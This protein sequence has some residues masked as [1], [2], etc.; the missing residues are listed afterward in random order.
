MASDGLSN[1]QIGDRLFRSPHGQLAPVPVLSQARG[2][3]PP[4]GTRRD[5]PR[6]HANHSTRKHRKRDPS[7]GLLLVSPRP[8][9]RARP[10][11]RN[12]HVR[13]PGTWYLGY[14]GD[15]LA[16][17]VRATEGPDPAKAT[18]TAWKYRNLP[19]FRRNWQVPAGTVTCGNRRR[20]PA[21]EGM[22]LAGLPSIAQ[23]RRRPEDL[24]DRRTAGLRS[25]HARP[26]GRDDSDLPGELLP[27][28]AIWARAALTGSA[29]VFACTPRPHPPSGV[30]VSSTQVRPAGGGVAGGR[31]MISARWRTT[32]SCLTRCSAKLRG[33]FPAVKT[34]GTATPAA[35]QAS[36]KCSSA[37]DT[38]AAAS[39]RTIVTR[40]RTSRRGPAR[41]SGARRSELQRH[42]VPRRTTANPPW[43]RLTPFS[44]GVRPSQ[45]GKHHDRT[46]FPRSL[47]RIAEGGGQLAGGRPEHGR[48][49]GHHAGSGTRRRGGQS[50][51]PGPGR[52]EP[53]RCHSA[54]S[55]RLLRRPRRP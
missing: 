13:D 50:L 38:P 23:S 24:P 37:A 53:R 27:S 18:G 14:D 21:A 35:Q 20:R 31:W 44:A 26:G 17:G 3:R 54:S 1:R 8:G 39:R 36:A 10:R 12:A 51:L 41:R 15:E 46:N 32:A 28:S 5:R 2:R 7:I 49:P 30:S 34:G 55:G 33:T 9:K 25:P 42:V 22:H 47:A 11:P 48:D 6:Q 40:R 52:A 45:I 4:P 19:G 16:T 43:L 29:L